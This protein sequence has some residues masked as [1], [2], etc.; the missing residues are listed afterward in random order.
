MSTAYCVYILSN[1]EGRHYIGL[2]SDVS[3]RLTQ[4]NAG[5]SR[6]TRDKGPWALDWVS[7]TMSLSEATRLERLLKRQKGGGGL[8]NVKKTFSK[9]KISKTA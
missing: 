2:T 7:N 8:E 9:K 3:R 5:I 6:W 1:K 4:H